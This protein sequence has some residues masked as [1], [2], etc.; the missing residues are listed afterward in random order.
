MGTP[1]GT[2][3]ASPSAGLH[4]SLAK[5]RAHRMEML[6]LLCLICHQTC[7]PRLAARESHHPLSHT[8]SVLALHQ[9]YEKASDASEKGC[10]V[11]HCNGI[12]LWGWAKATGPMVAK[13]PVPMEGLGLALEDG[14]G[15]VYL[16]FCVQFWDP[17]HKKYRNLLERVQCRATKGARNISPMRKG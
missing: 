17:W 2:S 8:P 7:W 11:P 4:C 14:V 6:L 10:L 12:W 5:I 15:F 9:S 3:N 16:E 1:L 13:G